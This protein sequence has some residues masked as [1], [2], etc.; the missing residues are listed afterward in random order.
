MKA[1]NVSQNNLIEKETKKGKFY[2][3]KTEPKNI[4]VEEF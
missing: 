2:F 3:L 1:K 4:L